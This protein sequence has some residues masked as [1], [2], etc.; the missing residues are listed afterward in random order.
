[1]KKASQPPTAMSEPTV[2]LL[3]H[4]NSIAK[5]RKRFEDERDRRLTEVAVEREKALKIK[6]TADLKALDLASEIQAYKD[7]KA[8]ELRAQ[9]NDERGTYVTRGELASAVDKTASEVKP[10]TTYVTSQ[11]GRSS[12]ASSLV[13]WAVI[14]VGLVISVITIIGFVLLFTGSAGA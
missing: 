13:N 6:E 3:Y 12:G 10:L 5:E 2:S 4:L 9:I 7:E 14:A 8:N 1:M 11:L